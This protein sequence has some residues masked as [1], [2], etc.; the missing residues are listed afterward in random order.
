MGFNLLQRPIRPGNRTLI[1]WNTRDVAMQFNL[2][3]GQ[4]WCEVRYNGVRCTVTVRL[5]LLL[6]F[7]SHELIC[8]ESNQGHEIDGNK[9]KSNQEHVE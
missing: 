5:L 6:L 3:G 1:A 7:I 2:C 9:T 8:Y 4:L